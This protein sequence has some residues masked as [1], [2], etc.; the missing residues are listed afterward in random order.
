MDAKVVVDAS[1]WVSRFMPTDVNHNPSILWLNR[2][3]TM[4]GL[5]VEPTLLQIEVAAA[6]SRRTGQ[7]DLSRDAVRRLYNPDAMYFVPLSAMLVEA[8][9]D[10][11]INL[12]LRAGDAIY[13]ALAHQR[14]IP[15]I[16]WDR[17]QLE[18]ASGLI[19]AYTPENYT[20]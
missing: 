18:R 11:A 14:S 12:Q 15:L 9:V 10:I 17:E 13:V 2:F 19:A 4:G 7:T 1:V 5:L 6:I 16:S 3:T 20:F 8:S